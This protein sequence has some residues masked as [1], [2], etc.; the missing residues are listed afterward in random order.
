M[1]QRRV[2]GFDREL[3]IEWLDAVAARVAAGDS[4]ESARA[5]LDAHLSDLLGGVGRGGHRGKTIT[6]LSR[7]WSSVP[8]NRV[9]IRNRALA[10]LSSG[11]MA[12]RLGIHWAMSMTAYP[13]FAEVMG[14]V[15]R[16]LA[17]QGEVDRQAV[18]R[19]MVELWG[20]RPA[21]SRGS[22]AVWTSVIGWGVLRESER[23][24]RYIPLAAPITDTEGVV[25]LL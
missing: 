7:I 18:V 3:N 20:D 8:A 14:V 1:T 5:W 15:G 22:R 10:L 13:F 23:R 19:R 2:I 6:V 4:P 25:T 9:A 24:G 12:D 16:R 11:D 21:V 17:L